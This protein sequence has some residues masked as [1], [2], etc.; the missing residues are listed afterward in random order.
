M[1]LLIGGN[2]FEGAFVHSLESNVEPVFVKLLVR[3]ICGYQS[4]LVFQPLFGPL[5]KFRVAIEG[6]TRRMHVKRCAH[7]FIR[8]LVSFDF[9]NSALARLTDLE[10]KATWQATAAAEKNRRQ[11]N[12]STPG[13]ACH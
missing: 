8:L 2:C 3:Q 12:Y 4:L 9:Q 6:G 10:M 13:K 7:S 1:V 11:P 5:A